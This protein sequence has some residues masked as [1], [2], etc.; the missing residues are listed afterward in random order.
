MTQGHLQ[1][2]LPPSIVELIHYLQHLILTSAY[3]YLDHQSFDTLDT[4]LPQDSERA[5]RTIIK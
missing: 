1:S 5:Y 3:F 4:L 2:L